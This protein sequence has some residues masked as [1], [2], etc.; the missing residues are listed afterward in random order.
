MK[1]RIYDLTRFS[2]LSI[3][4]I[5]LS[6]CSPQ[7][8]MASMKQAVP[9]KAVQDLYSQMGGERGILGAP[10]STA[11]ED[12]GN[13]WGMWHYERGRIY[14]CADGGTFEVYGAI[15]N[16]WLGLGG[17][18]GPIGYPVGHPQDAFNGKGKR[19]AFQHAILEWKGDG[20]VQIFSYLSLLNLIDS[21]Q[22]P[23]PRP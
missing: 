14:T 8:Q 18:A 12:A 6:A 21:K 19:Q 10:V 16:E 3:M 7:A 11:L 23:Y 5:L 20:Q 15:L 4:V 9:Q 22:S 2:I 1:S 17:G 13:G